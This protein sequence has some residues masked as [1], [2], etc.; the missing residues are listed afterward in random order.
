MDEVRR[1]EAKRM[2]L[3][4]RYRRGELDQEEYLAA[5]R[6]LDCWMDA[7]EAASLPGVFGPGEAAVN[8][9][10]RKPRP[11]YLAALG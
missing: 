6:P 11:R 4:R 5:I 3:Y 8:T 1:C 9:G 2:E 7:M 10:D